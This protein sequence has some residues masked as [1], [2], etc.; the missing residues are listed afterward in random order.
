MFFNQ[1]FIK[2]YNAILGNAKEIRPLYENAFVFVYAK[3]GR[4]FHNNK[5]T[6]ETKEVVSFVGNIGHTQRRK[7]PTCTSFL[8]RVEFCDSCGEVFND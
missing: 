7:C 3:N 1:I 2:M 5:I 4:W 8:K 6:R